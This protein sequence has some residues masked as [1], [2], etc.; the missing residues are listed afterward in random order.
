MLFRSLCEVPAHR[1]LAVYGVPAVF[2]MSCPHA[3][4]RVGFRLGADEVHLPFGLA[5]GFCELSD[6]GPTPA[7]VDAALQ[8]DA[9][10]PMLER[11][12]RVGALS[13]EGRGIGPVVVVRVVRLRRR[14]DD[15]GTPRYLQVQPN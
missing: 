4:Q 7:F 5:V 13:L 11:L 15:L 10:A 3:V 14:D 12:Q 2:I 8:D 1:K 6:Q 9:A